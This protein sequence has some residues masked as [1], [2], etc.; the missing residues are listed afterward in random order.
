MLT[1]LVHHL[2]ISLAQS[3]AENS[4]SI[5]LVSIL[6]IIAVVALFIGVVWARKRMNPNEDVHGEGFSLADLRQMHKEG[7][8]SDEEYERA[9]AKM[10]EHLQAAQARRDAARAEAAKQ[11]QQRGMT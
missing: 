8:L 1:R 10:V 3:T 9:R 7:H 2:P 5:L 4:S 6:L 11:Q